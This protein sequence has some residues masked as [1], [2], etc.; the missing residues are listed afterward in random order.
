MNIIELENLKEQLES[1]K[2]FYGKVSK[3]PLDR[4]ENQIRLNKL[5]LEVGLL[6]DEFT[7]IKSKVA[8]VDRKP[9][10]IQV[11]NSYFKE[12]EKYIYHSR[13]L[14]LNRLGTLSSQDS[15]VEIREIQTV[16]MTEKFDLRTASSLLPLMDGTEDTTKQLID[17]IELYSEL[18]DE[19]GQKLMIS[20][21]LKAR[22]SQNAKLRLDRTYN[23]VDDLVNDMRTHLVSKKSATALASALHSAKQEGKT[24][25]NYAQIIEDLFVN[26]T[27]AQAD[28][29]SNNAAILRVANEKLAIN[30]FSNGLKNSELRTVIKARN[31]STLKEAI[32]GAKDEERLISSN[33]SGFFH[34]RTRNNNRFSNRGMRGRFSRSRQYNNSNRNAQNNV[35]ST[36]R[37]FSSTRN[38]RGHGRGISRGRANYRGQQRNN[39]S[40]GHQAYFADASGTEG[41]NSIG[42]TSSVSETQQKFFRI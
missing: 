32:V 33:Q 13:H 12:I 19:N 26:L 8:K 24:I 17:A 40:T 4:R 35:N 6:E 2:K 1:V 28:G 21:V 11:I 25:D 22:L 18:L 23:T 41:F 16:K 37:N 39:R 42:E 20:Y 29:N 9:E 15:Q 3:E 34:M 14:L 27:I 36:Q 31:Y 30:V 10:E 5:L 7:K 38:F